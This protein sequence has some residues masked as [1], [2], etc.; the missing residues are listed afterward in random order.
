MPSRLEPPGGKVSV[1]FAEREYSVLTPASA[2]VLKP[3][4]LKARP[5]MC[6]AAT[7]GLHPVGAF[8][9]FGFR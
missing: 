2:L 5:E 3:G 9:V 8:S 7:L 1:R 4:A 6:A